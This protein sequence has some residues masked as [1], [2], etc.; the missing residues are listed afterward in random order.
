MEAAAIFFSHLIKVLLGIFIAQVGSASQGAMIPIIQELQ[1]LTSQFPDQFQVEGI[2]M[3]RAG[4]PLLVGI[5]PKRTEGPTKRIY[6]NGAHHGDE[7]ITALAT[8][9]LIKHLLQMDS[10]NRERALAGIQLFIQPV[11][12]PDGYVS[13]VRYDSLGFDPNRD[14]P[15]PGKK[16]PS[17]KVKAIRSVKA[18]M[19]KHQF[20]GAL[21]LHS[22]MVGVLW[23]WCHTPKAPP[24]QPDL[25]EISRHRC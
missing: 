6:I 21:T 23:P 19:A 5:I 3:S 7:T 22:G 13:G 17:F 18:F 25:K 2:G 10:Y 14:Y 24:P 1:R 11:V 8:I 20:D 12:N 16:T 9:D 15:Y 4:L